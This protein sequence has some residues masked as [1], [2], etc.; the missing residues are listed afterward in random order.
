MTVQPAFDPSR[1]AQIRDL[2]IET[3]DAGASR[4]SRRT[5]GMVAALTGLAIVLAGGTAALALTGVI[6]FGTDSPP[7]VPA[8]PTSVVP[9]PSAPPTPT[10]A[11][12]PIAV[13]TSPIHRHDT[14]THPAS[15][16]WGVNLPGSDDLCAQHHV[17]DV[18]DGLALFQVGAKAVGDNGEGCDASTQE[19]GLSL[20]DTAHGKVIWSRDWTWS[21]P[22]VADVDVELLGDS[23]HVAVVDQVL[24]GGP[25]EVIDLRTGAT[26][27]D[28]GIGLNDAMVNFTAVPDGSGDVIM[29]TNTS[30]V[31]VDPLDVAHPRWTVPFQSENFSVI[32]LRS[33]PSFVTVS[34]T[35]GDPAEPY[36]TGAI[37]MATGGF[38]ADA[39]STTFLLAQAV[40]VALTDY[41][42]FDQPGTLTGLDDSGTPAWTVTTPE[43]AG[44]DEVLSV[45][46]S[47]PGKEVTYAGTGL[48]ALVSRDSVT[49]VDGATGSQRW[50]ASAAH[51]GFTVTPPATVSTTWAY[52]DEAADRLIVESLD[53]TCS[54]S[55][56]TGAPD[57]IPDISAQNQLAYGPHNTYVFP[58][59][60]ASEATAYDRAS[61][62]QLW[63]A[64]GAPGD[65]WMFAG[66]YLV[67]FAGTHVE[68]AG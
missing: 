56:S 39:P 42:G 52:L 12:R 36:R 27:G 8:P 60:D 64:S 14:D 4:P 16:S 7:P 28:F 24:S 55:A 15:P 9:T 61:G 62:R 66:G 67:R 54:F 37:D 23:G 17:Y 49:L 48:I 20:V 35:T 46:G 65:R 41:R 45:S 2:L 63:K 33:D 59:G 1:S 34:Y 11:A 21:A 19:V 10:T 51:C 40:T 18:A 30:V 43:G 47:A 58:F 50:Q 22:P 3:V 31:R 25:H 44:T 38:T 53:G 26:L 29:A 6:R 32:P 68:S 13:Q 57:P 5:V